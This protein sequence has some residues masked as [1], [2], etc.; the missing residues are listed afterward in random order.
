MALVIKSKAVT[1]TTAGTPVTLL[2]ASDSQGDIVSCVI[3][4][5]T[6][7]IYVG[8]STVNHSTPVGHKLLAS[9][10][11]T[12]HIG[13]ASRNTVDMARIY[14]D[15]STNGSVAMVTYFVRV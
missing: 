9:A 2:G 13:D 1:V 15:A 8:D 5:V 12:L 3:Q 4:A 6:N 11:D 14:L 7:T 10:N